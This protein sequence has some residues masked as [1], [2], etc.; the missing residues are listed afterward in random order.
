MRSTN[1]A[2][3]DGIAFIDVDWDRH[4]SSPIAKNLRVYHRSTLVM[5][6]SEGEVGRLLARIDKG[7]IK[8]LLDRGLETTEAGSKSCSR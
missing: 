3:D 7:L 2:Y 6:T 8:R 4:R 5:L 1:G